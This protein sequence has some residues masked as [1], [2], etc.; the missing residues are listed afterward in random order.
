MTIN[1]KAKVLINNHGGGYFCDNYF[2]L[3]S[4]PRTPLLED[5]WNIIVYLIIGKLYKIYISRVF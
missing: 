5:L 1:G 4:L 3:I 2:N